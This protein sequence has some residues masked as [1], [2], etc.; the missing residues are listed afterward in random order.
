MNKRYYWKIRLRPNVLTKD[1][2]NDYVAELSATSR[3]WRNED[4]AHK[5]VK[6]CSE[7][8]YDTI[9][10]I[11]NERDAMVRHAALNGSP[12]QDTNMH[13]SPRITGTWLGADPLFEPRKHK[14]TV[15]A[16]PTVDFRHAL[17][18]EVGVDVLGRKTDAGALIGL[19]RDV[20][21]GKT[22]GTVSRGGDLIIEGAKIRVAPTDDPS[23]GVFFVSLS[24]GT[25]VALDFPL[26]ENQPKRLLCRTPAALLSGESYEL[27]IVTRYSNGS[28]ALLK[29][30]RTIVYELPLTPA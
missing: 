13:L 22:D 29:A 6:A 30:P 28:N 23:Q 11:L 5:I 8:R 17:S 21:T 16:S 4:V 10:S 18:T 2:E 20:L 1:V 19:V 26:T 12:V 27:Q 7:L 25:S 3:T 15:D 14:I 9:L 24:S